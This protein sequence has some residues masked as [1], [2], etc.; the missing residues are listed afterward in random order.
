P[1]NTGFLA[2]QRSK[3]A[4]VS[5]PSQ[6]QLPVMNAHI[7]FGASD[8]NRVHAP[9]EQG[10]RTVIDADCSDPRKT[11]FTHAQLSQLRLKQGNATNF[12]N[13]I[14]KTKPRQRLGH[15]LSKH[16]WQE[17]Q[18]KSQRDAEHDEN[19]SQYAQ[20]PSRRAFRSQ[21]VEAGSPQSH[22]KQV[23]S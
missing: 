12:K 17:Q 18:L 6:I 19:T 20:Y 13:S 10:Q 7:N 2:R 4:Q 14:A 3:I 11:S 1:R 9:P 15:D 21:T 23:N 5:Q 16:R 8:S 22:F